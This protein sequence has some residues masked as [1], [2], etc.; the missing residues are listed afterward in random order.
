[1]AWFGFVVT[2][3]AYTAGLSLFQE[4]VGLGEAVAPAFFKCDAYTKQN[5]KL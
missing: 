3:C 4:A 2:G 1:M 5:P